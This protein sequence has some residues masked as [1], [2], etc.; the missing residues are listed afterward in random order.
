MFVDYSDFMHAQ[1]IKKQLA[2]EEQFDK[3]W[4]EIEQMLY[5]IQELCY[6]NDSNI[7]DWVTITDLACMLGILV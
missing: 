1:D 2:S 5:V 4:D 6:E 3:L 7:F